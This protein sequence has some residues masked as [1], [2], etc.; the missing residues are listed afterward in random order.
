MVASENGH[1]EVVDEL[2]QH[3]AR[4]NLQHSVITT[5]AVLLKISDDRIAVL[6]VSVTLGSS[7]V[8]HTFIFFRNTHA[9]TPPSQE[10]EWEQDCLGLGRGRG[11]YVF[12]FSS[13]HKKY[14]WFTRLIW[15]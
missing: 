13:P 14:G 12:F 8:N 3:G 10:T 9:H 5:H 7:F 4:V 6:N 1:V 2:L 11:K 15:E